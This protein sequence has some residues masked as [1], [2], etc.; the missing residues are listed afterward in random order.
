[1]KFAVVCRQNMNRS[2][3]AHEILKKH[4]FHV[5]SYGTS[6][7]I[8]FPIEGT[9]DVIT[10]PFS[11]EYSFLYGELYNINRDFYRKLGVLHLLSENDIIKSHPHRFQEIPVL[12]FDIIIC[13]DKSAYEEVVYN[14]NNRECSLF[15]ETRVICIPT[16]DTLEGTAWCSQTVLRLAY[17]F[18]SLPLLETGL[19]KDVLQ[20]NRVVDYDLFI[21]FV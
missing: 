3:R 8:Y 10:Y 7:G 2:M 14:I 4:H 13:F 21:G 6:Q 1:M 18:Q 5:E 9:R 11:S 19:I 12:D 20:F 17:D 16:P 15:A